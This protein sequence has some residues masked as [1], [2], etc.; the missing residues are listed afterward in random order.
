MLRAAESRFD[1]FLTTDKNL[2][3]QQNLVGRMLR[4]LVLPTTNWPE[5][6][7]HA[8]RVRQAVAE[9]LPGEYRELA[10]ED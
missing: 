8:D 1:L 6:Q 10:W 7:R 9:M 5:I 3:Y 4:I 2:Q